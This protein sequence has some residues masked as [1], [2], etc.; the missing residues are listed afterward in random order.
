[1]AGTASTAYWVNF[2]DSATPGGG[3]V[4]DGA[5]DVYCLGET[6]AANITAVR[7]INGLYDFGYGGTGNAGNAAGNGTYNTAHQWGRCGSVSSNDNNTFRISN[8]VVGHTYRLW[9][10]LGLHFATQNT[11]F[12]I[13]K[14]NRVNTIPGGDISGG[15]LP[16]G[17]VMDIAG[18]LT[19]T[20]PAAWASGQTFL[21]WVADTNDL[22]FCKNTTSSNNGYF[23]AIGIEDMTAG[24]PAFLPRGMLMGFG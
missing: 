7:K 11:G 15:S 1:M 14:D 23:N 3:F 6:M 16:S 9:M 17:N 10:S 18:N 12:M 21:D 24:A 4:G 20:S 22:Y 5:Q 2:R 13:Y 8:L 19:F